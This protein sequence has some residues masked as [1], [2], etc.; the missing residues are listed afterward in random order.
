MYFCNLLVYDL[1][2]CKIVVFHFK[3][4]SHSTKIRIVESEFSDSVVTYSKETTSCS[5]ARDTG[6]VF[7]L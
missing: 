2:Y 1:G 3:F 4:D 7:S 5:H 6:T